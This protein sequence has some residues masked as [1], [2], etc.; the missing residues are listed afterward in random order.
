MSLAIGRPAR[1]STSIPMRGRRQAKSGAVSAWPESDSA[2]MHPRHFGLSDP[3][4]EIPVASHGVV[5]A[6][7]AVVSGTREDW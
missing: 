5:V 2:A 7:G 4:G 1:F 3:H 6:D